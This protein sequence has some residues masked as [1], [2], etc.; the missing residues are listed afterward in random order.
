MLEAASEGAGLDG[1]DVLWETTDAAADDVIPIL[2]GLERQK[3]GFLSMRT[4]TEAVRQEHQASMHA[5]AAAH[6]LLKKPEFQL[7]ATQ[8]MHVHVSCT[9]VDTLFQHA[10]APSALTL[11]L[12]SSMAQRA[13][14]L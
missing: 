14:E 4:L 6:A 11:A 12:L 9:D 3:H 10:A 13:G 7:L 5:K 8:A 2:V 1:P